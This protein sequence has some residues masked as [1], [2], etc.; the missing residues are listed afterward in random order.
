MGSA[1][2]PGERMSRKN[3]VGIAHAARLFVLNFQ[4][5]LLSLPPLAPPYKGGDM[6]KNRNKVF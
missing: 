1:A 6:I 3:M 4:A 5:M 2:H